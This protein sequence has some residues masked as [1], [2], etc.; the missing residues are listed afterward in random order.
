M[1]GGA[2][3]F[4]LLN[5]FSEIPHII[6]NDLN[7]RLIGAY[8]TIRNT[9]EELVRALKELSN[10][11]YAIS[12]AQRRD[13][14]L[15]KRERFNAGSLSDVEQTALLLFLN[16]TCF[17]GIYRENA[18][19]GFNVPF[20]KAANPT[21]C[22][23]ELLYANARALQNTELLCGD[24]ADTLKH[25]KGK[26]LFYLDPPYKPIS[27]TSSFNTYTKIPFNDREQIRLRDF[28]REIDRQGHLFLLSNSDPADGFFDNLYDGFRIER[29][30]AKRCVNAN[31]AK[32]GALDE[33]LISNF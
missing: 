25:V 18:K 31:A 13:F 17:N 32:R 30:K 16:R 21:I 11:Y 14:Y 28:C 7:A 33:L 15:A 10:S 6:V 4:E 23:P 20:G 22:V 1:A 2:L 26:T 19:G 8:K 12:E 3:L 5:D 29:V 9:P 27:E 24:F